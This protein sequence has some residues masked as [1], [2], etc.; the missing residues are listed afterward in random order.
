MA[1]ENRRSAFATADLLGKTF[2]IG[3]L[4]MEASLSLVLSVPYAFIR[5]RIRE[6]YLE[7]F[8]FFTGD[9]GGATE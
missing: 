6:A 4:E 8:S 3:G 9:S 1:I 2:A 5:D 7:S